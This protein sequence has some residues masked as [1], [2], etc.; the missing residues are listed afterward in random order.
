M[1]SLL[2][3]NAIVLNSSVTKAAIITALFF[4]TFFP[5]FA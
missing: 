4:P 5:F 3:G 2:Y 1:A